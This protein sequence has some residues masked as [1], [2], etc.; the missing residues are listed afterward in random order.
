MK[1]AGTIKNYYCVSGF[2]FDYFYNNE[3]EAREKFEALKNAVN[4]VELKI[5]ERRAHGYYYAKSLEIAHK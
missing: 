4:Y 2:G 5:C 1:I 3:T